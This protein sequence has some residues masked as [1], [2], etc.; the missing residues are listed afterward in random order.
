MYTKVDCHPIS[1]KSLLR[2]GDIIAGPIPEAAQRM[3]VPSPRLVLNQFVTAAMR[4][5]MKMAW[6]ASDG[7][8]CAE[9]PVLVPKGV[10]PI[11]SG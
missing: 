6:T 9:S 8:P 1:T 11:S 10:M 2:R 3:P 7:R 5:T 4:G